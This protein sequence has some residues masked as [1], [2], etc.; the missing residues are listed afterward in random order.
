MCFLVFPLMRELPLNASETAVSETPAYL[1]MSR[2]VGLQYM[3]KLL[4]PGRPHGTTP[5]VGRQTSCRGCGGM[6]S[7]EAP[8]PPALFTT[9]RWPMSHTILGDVKQGTR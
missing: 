9:G 7:T 5:S 8:P 6:W 2:M 3:G 4:T 1:A